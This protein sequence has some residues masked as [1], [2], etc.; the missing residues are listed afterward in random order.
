MNKRLGASCAVCF[1][2][3]DVFIGMVIVYASPPSLVYIMFNRKGRYIAS[4]SKLLLVHPLEFMLCL[5]C[6]VGPCRWQHACHNSS[7][8]PSDLVRL[9]EEAIYIAFTGRINASLYVSTAFDL[10]SS[11]L[12]AE[13]NT[14]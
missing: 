14:A 8:E 13:I 9:A 2:W 1:T 12:P 7:I 11:K 10:L 5:L 6:T 3:L 4:K